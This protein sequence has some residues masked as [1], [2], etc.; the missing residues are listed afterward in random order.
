MFALDL[1]TNEKFQKM[2]LKSGYWKT[3]DVNRKNLSNVVVAENQ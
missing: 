3:S 2:V 1:V